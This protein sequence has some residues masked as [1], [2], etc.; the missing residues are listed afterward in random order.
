[1]REFLHIEH[2]AEL[3]YEL[4]KAGKWASVMMLSEMYFN[5]SMTIFLHEIKK[6]KGTK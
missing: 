1:M 3:V 2:K 6:E 5:Q 4:A